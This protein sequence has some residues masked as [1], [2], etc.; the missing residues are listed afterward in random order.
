[1]PGRTQYFERARFESHPEN[2]GTPYTI[3]LGQF[4][5]RIREE[6]AL[7]TGPTGQ[8]FA[9]NE[10]V[11]GQLGRPTGPATTSDGAAQP[12]EQGLLLY[13]GAERR[14]FALCGDPQAGTLVTSGQ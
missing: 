7:L 6:N 1:M 4:G 8:L 11:R 13:A 12:F 9:G 5:R 3:L 10:R 14:I 2:A